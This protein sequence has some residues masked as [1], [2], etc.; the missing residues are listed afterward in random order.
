MRGSQKKDS[1]LGGAIGMPRPMNRGTGAIGPRVGVLE[2]RVLSCREKQ[3]EKQRKKR[4]RKKRKHH[5]AMATGLAEC[6][7]RMI[8]RLHHSWLHLLFSSAYHCGTGPTHIG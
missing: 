7:T 8:H 3:K 1:R 5:K 2:L 4:T 6:T